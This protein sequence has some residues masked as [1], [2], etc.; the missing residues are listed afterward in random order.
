MKKGV[1]FFCCVFCLQILSAQRSS[2]F[3]SQDRLFYEA[4]SMYE[5][6]NY[7]GC[8]NKLVEYKKIATNIELIS[9]ADY[10]LVAGSY[11]QGK[12]NAILDLKDFLDSY[13]T[14]AHRNEIS[15][16]IGS[17]HFEEKDYTKAVY[18][19]EQSNLDY[20]AN[21]Q[22]EEY[23]YRMAVSMLKTDKVGEAQRLF[24][25]LKDNSK[26]Y[27]Q[28][29][30]YYLGY[31][32]YK[33]GR[34]SQASGYFNHLKD[35]PK[36][37][38]DILYY[39]TQINFAQKRY[40]QT[41][42]EGKNLLKLYPQNINNGEINRIVGLSYFQE[43]DYKEAVTYLKNGLDLSSEY[44]R[45]DYYSFGLANYFDKQYKDAIKYL[46]LS[47][48]ANDALGQSIYLYLGQSYLQLRD[49]QN[50]LLAFGSA[51][52]LDFDN[53]AKEAAMYN[54]A[55]LLHQNSI[56]A[57]GE[58]VTVL[59]S[60]L[61]T[62]PQSI[63]ADRVNNALVDVY[64]TT[65]DYQTALNSIAKI[66]QPGRRILEARQKIYYYLGTIEF[67]N[68]NYDQAISN[69]AL[70]I[71]AGDYART[72]K[73]EALFWRGESYYKKSEYAKAA[74]D[75]QAFIQ[76]GN[77]SGNL[78]NLAQYNLAYCAFSLKQYTK[79]Q[80]EFQRFIN[81]EKDKSQTLADA[82]ARLGDCYFYERRFQDAE[83]TYNQAV[84]IS[85]AMGAYALFQ[86]GYVM[87]LQKNYRGKI[88]QMDKLATEYPE[89]PYVTEALYE[90]GRSYVLLEDEGNAIETFNDLWN[91]FPESSFARKA[92]L[93]I[94][95][96]YFKTNQ[97]AKASEVYKKIVSQYPGSQEA[98]TAVQDL[99]SVYFEL[100]DVNAYAEYVRSLGG[101]V[102]FDV[103]E[104]DSLTYLSAERFFMRGETKQAQ[105]SLI[106]Y[107]QS[108]PEG[109]FRSNAHFYLGSIYYQEG[110]FAKAREEFQVVLDAG[111]NQHT[112]ESVARLAEINFNDK[113]YEAAL[114]LYE[115][116]RNITT[117]QTNKNAANLGVL[118][119]AAKLSQHAQVVTATNVLL[120]DKS[121][122][123]NVVSEAK[124]H[125]A[126]AYLSIGENTLAERDLTDL[127]VDT[128]TVWGA[129]AKYLLAQYYFDHNDSSKGKGIV[130]DYIKQG[131]THTYWL[132]R[133]FILLSDIFKSEG[134]PLQA[135]QY[136]ESL[137]NNYTNTNDDII[138]MLTERLN[139][140][141]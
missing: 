88:S 64:L 66:K 134:D 6:Q 5:E 115:R 37:K 13:P 17:L 59:E 1:I 101:V 58:S 136:L 126:K 99:K 85:P 14:T 23:A 69:F 135:R 124:Y 48:P 3:I 92:G 67:T 44:Q 106:R 12:D 128:R 87:G 29:A 132:A 31:I 107:I 91:R 137:Q 56:S 61:N 72:E 120:E 25:L 8:I 60:F 122:Q 125:R 7:S 11:Y 52:R 98:R 108:F 133:S 42:N 22:Q 111:S 119:S 26:K 50:A 83:T 100:N 76:T 105:E 70:A 82:Y 4:K 39:T 2:Q 43:A 138:P 9:E 112:E 94:G 71:G 51:S 90:K 24:G 73:E 140:L 131:T 113:N 109:A 74:N 80:T 127:S 103:T 32:N 139:Q 63:Y 47:N 30:T 123:P 40:A 130:L 96:L 68:N 57:F 33:E 97:S 53:Q 95:M 110:T 118:R 27:E 18:W 77:R 65:K 36:Y 81:L 104:Q 16:M 116:L 93:Q 62:Y 41:I 19:F 10:F 75:F 21:E 129:E 121:Q 114:Q 89:S 28:E 86:K 20:L 117:N 35:N 54:Y 15:F 84:T 46:G 45:E 141:N 55:M 38:E 78:R 34:F 49:G 79:A 102:K